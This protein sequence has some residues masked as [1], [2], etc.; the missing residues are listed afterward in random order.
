MHRG[1]PG[2]AVATHAAR[3]DAHSGAAAGSRPAPGGAAPAAPAA[4]AAAVAPAGSAPP[5]AAIISVA[6]TAAAAGDSLDFAGSGPGF[7]IL[8][9]AMI[10]DVDEA[11]VSYPS[12]ALTVRGRLFVNPF[13][14]N[15]VEPCVLFNHGGVS[16]VSDVVRQKCR[17]LAK[18]GYIVFAPSYRGED[19]S[20]GHVEVAAG[21]V[22]DVIAA[23]Q[24]LRHHPGVVPGKFALVGASHGA[25]VSVKAL[26]RPECRALVR[27]VVAAYGV[28]DIDGWYRYLVDNGFDVHDSLSVRVYGEGP[29]DKPE[30]FA[31][32]NALALIGQLP[33][34]PILLVQ[35]AQD[36]TVPQQQAITM[37]QALRA[38]GR[39]QDRCRVYD[40]GGHGFLF[41]DDPKLHSHEELRDAQFAWDDILGF[42]QQTIGPPPD[43]GP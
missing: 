14:R 25:L 16:G 41:W 42:L 43:Y 23:L 30:A 18:Q 11:L 36:R 35:G 9:R 17:W 3:R 37:F 39:Q 2:G 5:A 22:D 4:P 28:M 15:D 31:A 32:R 20:D 1:A 33:D 24:I 13:S 27:G 21:E 40:H 29:K 19:G 7:T 10:D 34:A 6:A 26:V 38:A 12:G 8:E